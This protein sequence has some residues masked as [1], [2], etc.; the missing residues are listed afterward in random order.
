MFTK[1]LMSVLKTNYRNLMIETGK[2]LMSSS[3]QIVSE[4]AL[5][6]LVSSFVN[7]YLSSEDHPEQKAV[8][9][10]TVLYISNQMNTIILKYANLCAEELGGKISHL[11]HLDGMDRLNRSP[12]G[13][14]TSLSDMEASSTFTNA[15]VA[16]D[17]TLTNLSNFLMPFVISQ[18][19][20]FDFDQ[21]NNHLAYINAVIIASKVL[22]SSKMS[23]HMDDY[24]KRTSQSI[25][26][27]NAH[28][29]DML[30]GHKL[31]LSEN[32]FK[33][34]LQRCGESFYEKYCAITSKNRYVF[35][36][37]FGIE[38]LSIFPILYVLYELFN[39]GRIDDRKFLLLLSGFNSTN[40]AAKY[41][42]FA[43][44]NFHMLQSN[45]KQLMPI[46]RRTLE[47]DQIKKIELDVVRSI[48]FKHVFYQ[49]P[50][51]LMVLKDVSF[52]VHQGECIALTGRSGSGKSTLFQLLE[53][54]INP[55]SGEIFIN[56]NSISAYSPTQLREKITS[57]AADTYLF[58]RSLYDL[59][60][61]G[62]PETVSQQAVHQTLVDLGL[63]EKI[64]TLPHG[65]HTILCN[66]GRDQLSSGER[67]KIHLA[68][69]F[70]KNNHTLLLLDEATSAIDEESM[71]N[72][73]NPRLNNLDFK[74]GRI[75]FII[76][77]D[78][79]NLQ[80]ADRT[81]LVRDHVVSEC[82]RGDSFTFFRP[83]PQAREAISMDMEH[84]K[85]GLAQGV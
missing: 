68:R 70:L 1:I 32:S 4:F 42:S 41:L 81:L 18:Q 3:A 21:D 44:A 74:Q 65:I 25:I 30:R 83:V 80:F 57:V 51:G 58:N 82:R 53:K 24:Q 27:A 35:S 63:D 71:V 7:R 61:Y 23:V 29:D 39:S 79:K 31:I 59:L 8:K 73:I 11:I 85:D 12:L 40:S 66:N 19:A 52:K 77:H 34:E 69:V 22:L 49:S 15:C 26:L 48:E 67:Q 76:S 60:R 64:S 62:L 2:F 5:P 16:I 72:H 75:T 17:F 38:I 56:G 47:T 50:Q 54:I 6:L 13:V 46:Y 33:E 78:S 37:Y 9:L 55:T 10:A 36:V 20:L 43:Y 28:R 45:L 14:R 84:T